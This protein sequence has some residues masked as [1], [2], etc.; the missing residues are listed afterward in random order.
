MY[1]IKLIIYITLTPVPLLADS[2]EKTQP[3]I[4]Y[5][6]GG[7]AVRSLGSCL[8]DSKLIANGEALPV[9]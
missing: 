9:T 8:D 1:A 6:I 5:L 3:N 2:T 7:L 4:Q